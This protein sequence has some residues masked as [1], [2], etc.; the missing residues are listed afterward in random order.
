M[1]VIFRYFLLLIFL[2]NLFCIYFRYVRMFLVILYFFYSFNV[3]I[4]FFFCFNNMPHVI[5][6]LFKIMSHKQSVFYIYLYL[7]INCLK[8]II[9]FKKQKYILSR[10]SIKLCVIPTVNVITFFLRFFLYIVNSLE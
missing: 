3:I 5:L 2:I 7:F 4:F 1:Y 6:I 10:Y 8:R 9:K